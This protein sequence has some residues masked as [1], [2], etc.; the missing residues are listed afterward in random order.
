V[1]GPSFSQKVPEGDNRPRRV[2]DD[3]GFVDYVNPRIVVG[4]VC[5]WEDRVLLCRRAIEPRRGFWTVP[6][7]F[8]EEGETVE[9][10]AL[11]EAWEEARADIEIDG[12]LGVYSVPRFS[13]V[14]MMFRARL[15]SPVVSAG[16]ESEEVG[17]FEWSAI[18]WDELAFPSVLWALRD[19]DAVRGQAVFAT[20]SN[21]PGSLG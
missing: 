11:R 18:P 2:C 6:A 4:T 12:L 20:R 16:E 3:C 14:Q 1:S 10:G 5:T 9:A 21:P 17:L 8:L 15:R 7:G 19:F 13:Q